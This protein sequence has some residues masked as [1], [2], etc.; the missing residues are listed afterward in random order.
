M[1]RTVT[2]RCQR[3]RGVGGRLTLPDIPTPLEP[4]L[5]LSIRRMGYTIPL[6]GELPPDVLGAA[7]GPALDALCA[8]CAAAEDVS[9]G[10]PTTLL[11]EP[12]G[13]GT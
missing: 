9:T 10:H 8:S 2:Y 13:T 11:E 1:P 5:R 6:A 4:F 7:L 3:C 12:S